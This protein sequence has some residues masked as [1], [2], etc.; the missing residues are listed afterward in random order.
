MPVVSSVG[1]RVVKICAEDSTSLRSLEFLVGTFVIMPITGPASAK[2]ISASF[3]GT[4]SIVG[5]FTCVYSGFSYYGVYGH[6]ATKNKT[7]DI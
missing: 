1:T 3:N 7:K 2:L 4:T 5:S 6:S